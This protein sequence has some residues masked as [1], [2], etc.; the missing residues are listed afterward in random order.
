LRSIFLSALLLVLSAPLLADTYT[1]T[2]TGNDFTLVNGPF[3]TGDFVSGFF[4]T[5]S[6]LAPNLNEGLGPFDTP[7]ALSVDSFSFS[8]GY[9]TFTNSSTSLESSYF[10]VETDSAGKL[11]GWS[12]E[13]EVADYAAVITNNY[14]DTGGVEVPLP[15]S[16]GALFLAGSNRNNPG[17]WTV[18]DTP[19]PPAPSP[20][21][22]PSTLALMSTGLLG[23]FCTL[24]RRF[25]N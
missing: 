17:A 11:V 13:L 4:T 7:T 16:E 6:P 3:T 5:A 25:L 23:A 8:N 1:Y 10:E 24:R 2:Y 18:T 20:V 9:Q 21:P 14:Y 15:A 19:G 12:I 22:E